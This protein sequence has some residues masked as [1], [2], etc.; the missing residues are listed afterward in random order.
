MKDLKE[1]LGAKK[2]IDPIDKKA[3]MQ[4]IK[5]MKSMAAK[6]MHD[7][8]KGTLQKVTVAAPDKE[9]LEE[10]LEKAKE[11]V[12]S[13]EDESTEESYDMDELADCCES[14]EDIDK[15]MAKLAE[16]KAALSKG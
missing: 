9:S 5:D 13:Q 8:A 7:E 6:M 2:S 15:L 3:K 10:G 14:E 12:E 1:L 16:K 4:A 11:V